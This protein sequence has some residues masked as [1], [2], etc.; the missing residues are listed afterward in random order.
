MTGLSTDPAIF[1][2][3]ALGIY[4]LAIIYAL[5]GFTFAA[6]APTLN[7]AQ[8]VMGGILPILFLFGGMFAPP[9][10]M[11][12]GAR[13]VTVID[14]ITYAFR[15]IIPGQFVCHASPCPMLA[16]PAPASPTGFVSVDLYNY[17]SNR[18]EVY[19]EDRWENLG[20]LSIFVLVLFVAGGAATAFV[21][22][23]VR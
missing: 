6:A 15:L 4:V 21:R 7:V 22:H 14:P 18:Y 16:I 1:F 10:Q 3:H 23:I 13:W 9:S 17:V 20:Y 12:A 8:A 19:Y 11:A 2:T 5:I